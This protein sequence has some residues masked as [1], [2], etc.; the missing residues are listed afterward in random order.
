MQLGS[1]SPSPPP[2]PPT[3][4]KLP[5]LL[6]LLK[7][8]EHQSSA[9]Y[10]ILERIL[11]DVW[12]RLL[13]SA[14]CLASPAS[15]GKPAPRV[16]C[17]A[18]AAQAVPPLMGF[19]ASAEKGLVAAGHSPRTGS[20]ANRRQV[21]IARLAGRPVETAAG[22]AAAGS[23]SC[24][25]LAAWWPLRGRREMGGETDVEMRGWGAA[26]GRGTSATRLPRRTI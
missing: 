8:S 22:V 18:T 19:P 5:H 16:G 14:G 15:A 21:A 1:A 9:K 4:P 25:R 26:R 10:P 7:Q 17:A 3:P 6:S 2:L 11:T 23:T 24:R 12:P 20:T 13:P